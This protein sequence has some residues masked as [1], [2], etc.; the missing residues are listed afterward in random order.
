MQFLGYA[1]K[2]YIM[3]GLNDLRYNGASFSVANYQTQ[4]G[5][6]VEQ[7]INI[8]EIK[9]NNIILGSPP[10]CNPSFYANADYAPFTGGSTAKHQEYVAA[11]RTVATKH[12]TKYADVYQAMLRGGNSLV[13]SDGIHPND[14]GHQVIAN[15]MTGATVMS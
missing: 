1:E 11:V 5:E 6:I 12:K 13:S 2:I 7:L 4:L 3:S 15:A 10:Y 9:P 8:Y 14:A